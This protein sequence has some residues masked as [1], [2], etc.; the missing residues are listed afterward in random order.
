MMLARAASI[1]PA[2]ESGLMQTGI[3]YLPRRKTM[4]PLPTRGMRTK[5]NRRPRPPKKAY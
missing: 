1:D 3:E 2:I 5:R 4:R